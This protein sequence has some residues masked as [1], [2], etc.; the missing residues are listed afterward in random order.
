MYCYSVVTT[1]DLIKKGIKLLVLEYKAKVKPSQA[2]AIE[3]AIRTVQFVR[4]KAL[5]FWIDAAREAKTDKFA[6]NKYS[7][8]LRKEF[9][10]VED[11]NSM[12]VQ[13]AA[14]RAWSAISRFY[15]NCK[16]GKPGSKG[17]PR[18]QH[19]NRSVE[20]KTSGWK[21][22]PTKRCITFSD[23]KGIGK[24]RLMG[25]WDIHSYSTKLIKRVRI[26]RQANGYYVQFCVDT[27]CSESTPLTGLEIGL[28]MGLEY[29]LSDSNGNHEE[30]PHFLR[31]SEEL[32]KHCQ[33]RIYSKQKGKK[34][35]IKARKR[36]AKKHLK[37]SRQRSEHAKRLARRVMQSND[38]CAYENLQVRNL[39]KNHNLAKSIGDVGW[40]LFR[41]WL[42]H[43]ATKFG[44]IAVA[45]APHYTSQKCSSCGT[46]VKKSLST[47]TH[48][49]RCGCELQRDVK[50][51]NKYPGFS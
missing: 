14:E 35:R 44:K 46:I 51:S 29:F 5:R 27:E 2:L 37:I 30:N 24:L 26:V 1:A 19:D 21:L 3:E 42:E 32:V 25:K 36:Y 10:F 50:C 16:S 41:L 33:R 43:F 17:Y 38:L 45:V 18:F 49:C 31:K 11:L 23:K 12:A 9:S 39:M 34:N 22:H 13:S 28:D 15:D 4:N 7:T 47:R 40:R 8:E 48:V 6:L 20:Y